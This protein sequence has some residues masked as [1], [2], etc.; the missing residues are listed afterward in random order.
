MCSRG[1]T[2]D[3]LGTLLPRRGKGRGAKGP[4]CC[5]RSFCFPANRQRARRNPRPCRPQSRRLSE[6]SVFCTVVVLLV[7]PPHAF[8]ISIVVV[9]VVVVIFAVFP[10]MIWFLDFLS[11]RCTVKI[12]F[13]NNLR[14]KNGQACRIK[15]ICSILLFQIYFTTSEKNIVR[16]FL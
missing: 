14:K 7:F 16:K 10:A 13:S 9:V 15:S 8:C 6:L 1:A 11:H 5:I 3:R 12:I 4:P 2:R